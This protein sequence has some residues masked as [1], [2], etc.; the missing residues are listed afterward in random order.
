MKTEIIT[1]VALFCSNKRISAIYLRYPQVV[2]WYFL[3]KKLQFH[4]AGSFTNSENSKY[5]VQS[6]KWTPKSL[7]LAESGGQYEHL[8]NIWRTIEFEI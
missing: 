8:H 6:H 5:N 7:L 3:V 2:Y 1:Y 4:V